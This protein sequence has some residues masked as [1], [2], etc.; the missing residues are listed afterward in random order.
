M[1][2]LLKFKQMFAVPTFADEDQSRKGRVLH[3][4]LI[5]LVISVVAFAIGIPL[6]APERLHRLSIVVINLSFG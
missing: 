2:I 3:F 5:V 1:N 4:I 6:L